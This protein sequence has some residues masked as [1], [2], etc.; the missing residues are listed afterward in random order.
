MM[1]PTNECFV[2]QLLVT[3]CLIKQLAVNIE[4]NI[5]YFTVSGSSEWVVLKALIV[6]SSLIAGLVT[7]SYILIVLD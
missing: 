7:A 3:T 2:I 6:F 4:D 1:I 5:T